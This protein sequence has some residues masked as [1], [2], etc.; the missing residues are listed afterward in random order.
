MATPALST[1]RLSYA[2]AGVWLL[3][4]VS[5]ASWW[6]TIGL[7]LPEHLHRMFIWEGAAF[8]AL[9]IAGGVAMLLAIRREH[10]R[11]QAL[12]T[13]FMSFTHDLK[14]ALASVQ[15]QAEGLREDWP[16]ATAR[17]A[18][19]RLLQDMLRLQ[20]QLENSLFVAQP[21]GR[22]LHERIDAGA[23]I[24]RLAE[25]WPELSVTVTGHAD[26]LVDARGFEAVVRNLLQNAVVHGGARHVRVNVE[27]RDRGLV[28]LTVSDD[29]RGVP[30]EAFA[31]LGQPF[32]RAGRTGGSGVGL[33]VCRQLVTRM[34]GMLDFT[35]PTAADGGLTVW[36][37]LPGAR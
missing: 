15:L 34:H 12:E 24:E 5:L 33:Y 36:L 16:D 20:I 37:D 30:A 29:G 7:S 22:L 35:R 13:F 8:I 31:R 6:L 3:L 11:R 18:L 25:D 9:L 19:D 23:A 26:V 21:D 28:R 10:R 4:T 32:A 2:I 27:P 14:T 1:S 17:P